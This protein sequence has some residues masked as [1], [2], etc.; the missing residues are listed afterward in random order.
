MPLSTP[1]ATASDGRGAA[2]GAAANLPSGVSGQPRAELDE[3]DDEEE[4]SDEYDEEDYE[5]EE[6]DEDGEEE[7]SS[8]SF[9]AELAGVPRGMKLSTSR[10]ELPPRTAAQQPQ[11]AASSHPAASSLPTPS[12]E[13]AEL[14]KPPGRSAGCLLYTSP[15]P[16]D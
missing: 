3:G 12:S 1:S 4:N 7:A 13:A 10:G 9:A 2:L 16:R 5:S 8:D 6:D 11:A 15:S 14:S